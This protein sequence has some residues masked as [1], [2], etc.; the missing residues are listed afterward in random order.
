MATI[1]FKN[2]QTQQ[3]FINLEYQEYLE[4][5]SDYFFRQQC[6]R[7]LVLQKAGLC[8]VPIEEEA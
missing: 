7:V 8:S 1:E 2:Q 6:K 4:E 5:L 3:F